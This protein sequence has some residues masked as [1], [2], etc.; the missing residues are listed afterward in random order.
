MKIRVHQEYSGQWF[1]QQVDYK[2]SWIERILYPSYDGP[3]ERGATKEE[4][5]QKLKDHF[6]KLERTRKSREVVEV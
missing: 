1:A 3:Y 5:I 4:A 6:E 2:P